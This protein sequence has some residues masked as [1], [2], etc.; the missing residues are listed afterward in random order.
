MGCIQ[1]GMRARV[2]HKSTGAGVPRHNASSVSRYPP[3]DGAAG[4]ARVSLGHV[5]A[6]LADQPLET[7]R[8]PPAGG[9]LEQSPAPWLSSGRRRRARGPHRRAQPW[10]GVQAAA[11]NGVWISYS[12]SALI[13]VC[14]IGKTED[15]IR[16]CLGVL[17]HWC[18][19]E[20]RA[21]VRGDGS[22]GHKDGRR[23][24][25]R[26]LIGQQG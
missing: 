9:R 16:L 6:F 7:R 23:R 22:Q 14:G 20:R 25:P 8:L 24:R 17:G 3:R 13:I 21:M 11:K 4:P 12:Q 1:M 2:T 5:R 26:N 15:L 18:L 19:G 10:R